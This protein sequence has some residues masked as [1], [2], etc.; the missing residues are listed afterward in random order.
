MYEFKID[1]DQ[2]FEI[3]E[4]CYNSGLIFNITD[5]DNVEDQEDCLTLLRFNNIADA[6]A[7][8]L[9]WL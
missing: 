1:W 7:F 6:T 5:P 3:A 8:K 4:W 9:R 2:Q